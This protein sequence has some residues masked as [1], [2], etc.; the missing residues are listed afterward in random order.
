MS[1]YITGTADE[2]LDLHMQYVWQSKYLVLQRIKEIQSKLNSGDLEPN[3]GDKH[4][5]TIVCGAGYHSQFPY[6]GVGVLKWA[7]N[8]YL[9][10]QGFE[11][12]ADLDHG[13]ISVTL[14]KRF[15]LEEV[16]KIKLR[17]R[18]SA[19]TRE[20]IKAANI[21]HT[22]AMGRR[23]DSEEREHQESEQRKA[24]E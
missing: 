24:K 11:I 8:D 5:F 22:H 1:Y 13:N 3:K 19:A 21:L 15:S 2:K 10:E 17:N 18:L 9:L 14:Y 7:I 20:Q 23:T 12:S 6:E 16:E 4:V